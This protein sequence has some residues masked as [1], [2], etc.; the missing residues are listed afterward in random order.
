MRP[1]RSC[2]R[3][4]ALVADLESLD[5][6]LVVLGVERRPFPFAGPALGEL[7]LQGRLARL[8]E[9]RDGAGEPLGLS[10]DDLLAPVPQLSRGREAAL[11]HDIGVLAQ[12][13]DLCD[14]GVPYP[15]A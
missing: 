7:P 9:E 15:G 2:R 11:E 12:P 6:D 8:V 5:R 14:G 1:A 13:R 4:Q 10:L 3:F